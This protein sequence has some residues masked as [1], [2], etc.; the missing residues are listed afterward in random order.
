MTH[1]TAALSGKPQSLFSV[2]SYGNFSPSHRAFLSSISSH[3][4]PTSYSQ[5]V[6][7]PKWREAMKKELDALKLNN[8]WTLEPLPPGKRPIGCKWVFKIKYNSDGSIER[9]KARLVAKGYTQMEGLDYHETFAPVAKLV[10]VRC[11]LAVAAARG[12]ELHQL[13][14]NNAFLHGDLHEEVYM[15]PPPGI[16]KKGDNFVCRLRKSL[17]GLKQASR[18]WFEKFSNALRSAGYKQSVADYSLFTKSCGKNF[19]AVLVYVDDVIVTGNDTPSITWLKKYLNTLF[20]IK[21]LG[22]LKYFLGIEVARSSE[23]IFLSQRKYILD[24]LAETGMIGAKG[25]SFPMEQNLHLTPDDGDFLDDPS[26][27]RRLVGRLI[28]LTITRPDITYSVNILSQFMQK[29]RSTH[30]A[31][32]YRVLRY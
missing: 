11:L 25:C 6:K 1:S 20:H 8:T 29:P 22:R 7:D 28:Y 19:S 13:D 4:E 27:Y 5:A 3:V 30:M 9:Y 32:T 15:L 24:I 2:I 18:N 17:Y 26:V 21:N 16:N 10:T 23:G 12:W 14:V 31:A